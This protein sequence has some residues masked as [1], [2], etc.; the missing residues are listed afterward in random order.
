[1]ISFRFHVVSI[2]A[3]FLA[4][5]IGV[6]VGTTYVDGAVVNGL[7][8]R[9]GSVSDTLDVRKAENDRLA[10]QLE[11]VQGYIDTSGAYAVSGRLPTVPV[12]VLAARGIDD[13]TVDQVVRLARQAGAATPGVVW[14]EERW[15]LS[16]PDDRAALADIVGERP[17]AST[18]ALW[19]AAWS[20][21]V[22]EL[23]VGATPPPSAGSTTTSS[24]TPATA[25]P[26]PAVLSSLATAGFLALDPLGDDS[27]GLADLAGRS[28]R[29]VLITGAR[30]RAQVLSMLPLVVEA[31]VAGGLPTVVADVYVD[32][33]AAPARGT[34]VTALLPAG[35]TDRVAVVDDADLPEGRVATVLALDAVGDGRGGH[36]GYGRGADGVLPSWTPP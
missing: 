10:Q 1:M 23:T 3:V 25:A 27:T 8:N 30:A 13:K 18:P 28:P 6:V 9:I 21:V 11:A 32:A 20:A 31:P 4:I 14:L 33:P 19:D 5:A 7:R 12:L 22:Q 15:A 26:P 29:V 17:T 2:T 34:V 24:T 36:F 16:N 35:K